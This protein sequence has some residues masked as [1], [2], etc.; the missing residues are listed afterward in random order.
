M[1]SLKSS[2][3]VNSDLIFK[4]VPNLVD[5]ALDLSSEHAVRTLR[6]ERKKIGQFFTPKETAI[7]MAQFININ[8]PDF[9]LLD[10]G[11]GTGNLLS[12]VCQ[13]ILEESKY[14][15][16]IRIDAFECDLSVIPYL[17]QVLENCRDSLQAKGHTFQFNIIKEDFISFNE[18]YL[19][20]IHG[21]KKK[22]ILYYDA[23]ISNPPYYKINKNSAS[24]LIMSD[25][26]SGQPNIYSL[27]M[28][29]SAH[30]IK[31]DGDIVF[32]TPRSFCSGLY[33]KKIRN[34]F[35]KNTCINWIHNFESR[36]NQ[37]LSDS[38]LQENVI[39][40]TIRSKEVKCPPFYTS[41]SYDN[42]FSNYDKMEVPYEDLIFS[43]YNE[44]II[45]VP[46]SATELQ[47]IEVVDSW[48]YTL[49]DFGLKMSTGPVVDF[50]TKE[51]LREKY[52]EG[53]TAPLIWMQNL[54][55][56]HIL[57]PIND[58]KKPQAIEINSSTDGILLPVKNYIL[59]KRFTSKEQ[60][61]RVFATP[62]LK[63][64]FKDYGKIGFEN[65]LNYIQRPKGDLSEDEVI[66]LTVFLNTKLIDLFFR[67]M[68][69]N[70]QVNASEINILPIPNIDLITEIGANYR[71]IKDKSS[72][73]P[74]AFVG[75]LLGIDN[76]LIKKLK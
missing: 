54:A 68:N 11:A 51:N 32:I 3:E 38:I 19:E 66:G 21:E 69:G 48:E 29:L 76:D 36:K 23:V 42:S 63:D 61:R 20:N 18:K 33:Y 25:F 58:L 10:P 40:H 65:H 62:F 70:T 17:Q 72:I 4:E 57:W 12:A 30:M 8:K 39:I 67:A 47:V 37:F 45:R 53:K 64:E 71:K 34:W 35:L 52:L 50:R 7:Y 5:L 41:N 2:T 73:N 9:S 28:I 49:R 6:D 13:R 74:D 46:S 16:N 59:I 44:N 56:E 27:F 1:Y 43:K 60:K 26:I 15:M 31:E 55:G 14:S 24:A 75:K 22:D